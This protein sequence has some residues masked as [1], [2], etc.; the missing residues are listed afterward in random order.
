[1]NY[2]QDASFI[3]APASFGSVSPVF[4][5]AFSAGKAI[6]NAV[7]QISA[8]GVYE[9][10]LNGKRVGDFILAPGWT[11]YETRLQYQTYDVTALLS[12]EN[13]LDV[14][15]G[16][17][18][19]TG[20]LAWAGGQQFYSEKPAMICALHISYADGTSDCIVSGADFSV[21]K[22]GILD[23]EI[24]DGEVFD[25]RVEASD[26]QAVELYSWNKD[27][28]IVQEGEVV[29]EMERFPAQK[30]IV[31]PKG[32]R[33]LDFGQNVTGYVEW[34]I[35]AKDGDIVKIS[36]SEILD[37]EGNFYTEN[38]RSAKQEVSVTCKDGFQTYKPHFSFQGFRYIRLDMYPSD[39][40]PLEQFNAV[41][42]HSDMKRTGYFSCSNDKINQLFHNIIYGQKGN[43]LDVPTDCPQRDER[44]GWTGDA[45]VFC[46]TAS[47]N[48]DVEKFFVKWLND[49]K[50]DQYDYG[51]IPSVIPDIQ[52]ITESASSAAWGDAATV[53]PWQIYLTYGDK[54][55]LKNQ[56]ES[57]RMWVEYVRGHGDNA[58]LWDAP[59]H[60]FGDW[61][62]LDAE[63][64]SYMGATAS[65][66]IGSAFYAY[67]TSLLIKAGKVLGLDMASYEALYANIVKAYQERYIVDGKLSSFTQTAHAVTLYFGLAVD[68]AVTAKDLAQ[69]VIDN[70]NKLTTG[71]VGTPYL[72]HALADNGYAELA[73]S[74][75]LQE[76]F[77]S[78]LFS[79]NMGATTIWEHWDGMKAD[80]SLWSRDM[81]SFNHYAY[82]AV[83]DFMYG[84]VC[85]INTDERKPGFLHSILRP[86]A[87]SRLSFAE[88]SIETRYGMLKSKWE[89]TGGKTVYSFVVPKGTTASIILPGKTEEVGAGAHTYTI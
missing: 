78:W 50:A 83:A 9:A 58:F 62:G 88:A 43:F 64:G 38:L 10:F 86:V 1:M 68:V 35:T 30:L 55:V 61:L 17:G 59:H 53:C 5:R 4:R 71:F 14:T 52:R 72:L 29:R 24:Y 82:G 69:L 54:Q 3:S 32:E 79:V 67:S 26:W 57:M 36:H 16:K 25:F 23:S 11:S 49:L 75:L 73:Y 85:G 27:A 12:G 74:L 40:V 39:V 28:L 21:A 15:I 89:Q 19:C 66:L 70:G 60:H 7:L 31:T 2:L 20:R 44:L 84:V 81:N 45:Q 22:S 48:F 87:D 46:R 56:F 65:D 6:Q 34:S 37:S 80:G 33:V 41:V 76:A 8:L 63:E 18:W 47:Y 77:P 13:L 42:V 51:S